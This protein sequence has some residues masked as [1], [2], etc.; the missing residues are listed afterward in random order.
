M[1]HPWFHGAFSLAHQLFER[2]GRSMFVMMG[3][4]GTAFLYAVSLRRQ[5]G[6][7]DVL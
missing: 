3:T 5:Y 2:V 6:A 1:A 4:T 7:V